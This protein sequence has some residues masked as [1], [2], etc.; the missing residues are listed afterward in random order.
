[1][2]NDKLSKICDDL[3]Q[4][5]KNTEKQRDLL[6]LYLYDT[7]GLRPPDAHAVSPDGTYGGTLYRCTTGSGG[8][9]ILKPFG[10]G[11]P[12]VHLLDDIDAKWPSEIRI[13]AD[14]LRI[15]RKRIC[16]EEATS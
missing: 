3:T 7:V 10:C 6:L 1:M 5:L 4:R 15:Q 14:R 11:T 12:N 16:D 13:L 9:L 8:Y 2:K